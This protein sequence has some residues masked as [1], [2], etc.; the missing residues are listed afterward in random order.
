MSTLYLVHPSTMIVAGPSSSG[1]TVFVTRLLEHDMF[2]DESGN[3]MDRVL[4]FSGTTPTPEFKENLE[5]ICGNKIEFHKGLDEEIIE[6]GL[7]RKQN[8]IIVIDDLMNEVKDSVSLSH[9]FTRVSHHDN[10]TIIYLVQNIFEKGKSTS[11]VGKNSHYIVFM[12]NPKGQQDIQNIGKQ[13][14]VK[15]ELSDF[16]KLVRRETEE[17]YSY[18]LI[19]SHPQTPIEFQLRKNIFPGERTEI[20]ARQG[21]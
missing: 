1:K 12:R 10:C 6:Y 5:K 21:I 18:I 11:T 13:I 15:G 7:N 8:T 19:D 3:G 14:C 2:R 20:F 17:P 9:M 16:V 4:W